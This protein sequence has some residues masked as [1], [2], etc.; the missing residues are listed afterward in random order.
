MLRYISVALLIACCLMGPRC[1]CN[2][3]PT[4]PKG[5]VDTNPGAEIDGVL[6]GVWHRY[7]S[8]GQTLMTE[9]FG[10]ID[11]DSRVLTEVPSGTRVELAKAE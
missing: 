11:G 6:R 5:Q 3:S 7:D 8:T 1:S 2:D 4:G 10:R 9:N